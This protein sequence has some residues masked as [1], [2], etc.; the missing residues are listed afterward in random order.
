MIDTISIKDAIDIAIDMQGSKED[1]VCK[2][3]KEIV[4]EQGTKLCERC[5]QND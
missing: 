3:C 4:V 2:Q 1:M 5:K